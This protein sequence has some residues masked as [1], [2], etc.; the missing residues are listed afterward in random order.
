MNASK[1][2]IDDLNY[3]VSEAMRI[4]DNFNSKSFKIF[5]EEEY[6]REFSSLGMSIDATDEYRKKNKKIFPPQIHLSYNSHYT[7]FK[8]A[9]R[10]IKANHLEMLLSTEELV[11]EIKHA[12]YNHIFLEDG[13]FEQSGCTKILNKAFKNSNKKMKRQD[14]FFP[15]LA[16]GL[17]EKKV[18]IGVTEIISKNEILPFL[19][20]DFDTD[21]LHRAE[22]FCK[23]N[24]FPYLHFLKV[25]V[26][27]RSKKS[28][29]RVALQVA[30]FSIGILHVFSEHYGISPEFVSISTSPF[31]IYD[32]F[33]VTKIDNEKYNFNFSSKGK[34]LHSDIFWDKFRMDT[35]NDIGIILTELTTMAIEP[36][37]K[38]TIADRLIDSIYIF[39]SA[40]QDKDDS[41]RIVKFTTALERLVS[42]SSEKNKSTTTHNFKNRVASLV[43][44][45]H[46]DFEKWSKIAVEMY[47]VRSDIVHGTWSLYRGI[48]PLHVNDYSEITSKAILSAC[49]GFYQRGLES[50][51][52][53]VLVK[54]FYDFLVNTVR[55]KP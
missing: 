52:N 37:K 14:F 46:G 55:G 44:V 53:D 27:T 13:T 23:C 29:E 21:V 41:S 36:T 49:L 33:F 8:I 31:P 42:I 18:K 3:I 43:T 35:K 7:F 11:S 16:L 12:L 4:H 28:R 47:K 34:I 19:K 2:D 40:L 26:S 39:S 32:G 20:K 25:P 1:I 48:E 5:L 17:N 15:V 38:S 54:E 6:N 22:K 50:D 30:N 51:N 45:Y 9:Q 24:K 10:L